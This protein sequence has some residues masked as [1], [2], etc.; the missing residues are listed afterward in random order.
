MRLFNGRVRG[1]DRQVG[2]LV[3]LLRGHE[4]A[5]SMHGRVAVRHGGVE[6]LVRDGDRVCGSRLGGGG[7]S[8]VRS[9]DRDV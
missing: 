1:L 8:S 9:G 7:G 4:S 2:S 6:V 3:G 5:G